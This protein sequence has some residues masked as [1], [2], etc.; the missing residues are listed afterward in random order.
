MN[1]P[2]EPDFAFQVHLGLGVAAAIGDDRRATRPTP[3][4]TR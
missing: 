2:Y 4:H 3:R 1:L